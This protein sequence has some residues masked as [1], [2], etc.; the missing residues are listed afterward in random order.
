MAPKALREQWT[1]W[2]WFCFET[3]S[4]SY[5]QSLEK[6][7]ECTSHFSTC[8]LHLIF[9][10]TAFTF[11]LLKRCW[12]FR[13]YNSQY[14]LCIRWPGHICRWL[15]SFLLLI[16]ALASIAEGLLTEMVRQVDCKPQPQFYLP[17]CMLFIAV[18]VSLIYYQF[19][20]R[21]QSPRLNWLLLLYWLLCIT[22]NV[23]QIILLLRED[24]V[25]TEGIDLYS[26]IDTAVLWIA[27]VQTVL[28]TV[29]LLLEFY[30]ICVKV[31]CKFTPKCLALRINNSKGTL[32]S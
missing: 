20:E 15:V 13:R 26:V 3:N 4:S 2:T 24:G 27:V 28:F 29:L 12:R 19:A 21:W 14:I 18:I 30:V 25:I 11:L 23:W 8:L 5:V 17:G 22:F 1:W 10:I 7:D 6:R 32:L 31:S 9:V 16:C